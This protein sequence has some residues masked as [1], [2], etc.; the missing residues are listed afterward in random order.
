[1]Y[2]HLRYMTLKQRRT[3]YS[4]FFSSFLFA[5]KTF[6][7]DLYGYWLLNDDQMFFGKYGNFVT[8]PSSRTGNFNYQT[9]SPAPSLTGKYAVKFSASYLTVKKL[10]KEIPMEKW[11]LVAGAG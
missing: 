9:L 5:D 10:I 3:H 2:R 4:Y 8:N 1:M 6:P 7:I 11:A